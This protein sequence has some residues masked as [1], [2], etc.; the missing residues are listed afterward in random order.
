[1]KTGDIIHTNAVKNIAPKKL[2]KK[3]TNAARFAFVFAPN[4][5]SKVIIVDPT[6]AP[7]IRYTPEENSNNPLN[8]MLTK[9]AVVA[10]EDC[11]IPV[12]NIPNNTKSMGK[13]TA[14]NKFVNKLPNAL[15]PPSA[16]LIKS[17]P[18]KIV[19]NPIIKFAIS[20]IFGF[21]IS[22][23]KN[24]PTNATT[25]KKYLILNADKD[26]TSVV[27]AVPTLAPNIIEVAWKSVSIPAFT[28]PTTITVVTP[29]DCVTAVT[30][31]PKP[32]PV[33][34]LL[35]IFLKSCRIFPDALCVKVSENRIIP[36]R[37]TPMPVSNIKTE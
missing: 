9:T 11:V 16:L 20:F 3:C 36:S 29:E 33:K 31:T 14:L 26:T 17:S 7:I 6:L 1:M 12:N 25:I 28:R 15:L 35:L 34:R 24:A 21:L 13:L 32:N 27:N 22:S 30:P 37:K 5:A 2:N 23:R 8:I 10:V 4:E 18:T 19:P